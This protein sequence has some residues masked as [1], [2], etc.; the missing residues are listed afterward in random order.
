MRSC[1]TC[2]PLSLLLLSQCR[3]SQLITFPFPIRRIKAQRQ[4]YPGSFPVTLNCC[5]FCISRLNTGNWYHLP[6]PI[7]RAWK[8]PPNLKTC[9][10][11]PFVWEKSMIDSFFLFRCGNRVPFREQVYFNL[12]RMMIVPSILVERGSRYQRISFV[13]FLTFEWI[14]G[15]KA[16][17]RLLRTT[18]RVRSRLRNFISTSAM[19]SEMV[20][21]IGLALARTLGGAQKAHISFV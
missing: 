16:N 2:N 6:T 10:K 18:R 11:F 12:V 21:I 17:R 15:R 8:A 3:R 14:K 9:S 20:T 4:R 7:L 5:G 13:L 19:A 1:L